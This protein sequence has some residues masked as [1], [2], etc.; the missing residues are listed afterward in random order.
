MTGRWNEVAAATGLVAEDGAIRP[1]IFAEM[2]A[3]AAR[4]GS[5]N[6]G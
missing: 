3:L 2:S 4:T 5:A 6:L 1:T